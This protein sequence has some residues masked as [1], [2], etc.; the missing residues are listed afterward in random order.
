MVASRLTYVALEPITY[1]CLG[2]C[3]ARHYQAHTYV[4]QCIVTGINRKQAV[5]RLTPAAQHGLEIRRSQETIALGQPY[6]GT[7]AG[8]QDFRR[9]VLRGPWPVE[10]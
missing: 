1:Y 10:S 2:R 4:R 9:S 3:L 5:A 6:M 7:R 8:G